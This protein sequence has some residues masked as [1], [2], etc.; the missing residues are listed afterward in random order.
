[1][2]CRCKRCELSDNTSVVTRRKTYRIHGIPVVADV[3]IRICDNCG[4]EV[5]DEELEAEALAKA[6][7]VYK[8]KSRG[9]R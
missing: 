5:D 1:M 9:G 7:R 3:R 4:E 6:K 2:R 8:K